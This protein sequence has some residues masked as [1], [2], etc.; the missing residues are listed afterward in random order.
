MLHLISYN[1][2][3]NRDTNAFYNAIQNSGIWWHYFETTWI[4][5]SDEN[6]NQIYERLS[7][8][9]GTTVEYLL[10]VKIDPNDEQG[11]LPQEAWDWIRNNNF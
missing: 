1:I 10:I 7:P 4:V 6:S 5:R 2:R 8:F 9:V 11:W 3:E